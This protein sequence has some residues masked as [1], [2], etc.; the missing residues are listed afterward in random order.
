M[1]LEV[2]MASTST[3]FEEPLQPPHLEPAVRAEDENLKDAPPLD[4]GIGA[5]GSVPVGPLADNNVALFV[6]HL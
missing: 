1:T 3:H 6:L 5:L 2:S 4:A